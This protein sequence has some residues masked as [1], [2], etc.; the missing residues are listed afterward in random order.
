MLLAMQTAIAVPPDPALAAALPGCDFA[1]AFAVLVT[2]RAVD[3]R[4]AAAMA[5]SDALPGWAT[6][7]MRLR[8]A[9]AGRIGLKTAGPRKG[10]PVLRE[11]ADEVMLGLDDRHLDFRALLRVE[12]AGEAQSR[13]TLTTAVRTHNRL[14]R[15]YL[16]VIMPFHK[17]IIRSL[18][19][20]LA[21][22]LA[23]S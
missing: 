3:P 9:V 5:F 2:R 1:D 16:A 18:L 17:L 23:Q 4:Q 21:R 6:A 14:G 10:F 22:Q 8:N 19:R 20:R 15:V 11:S 13:I 12:V 7:L